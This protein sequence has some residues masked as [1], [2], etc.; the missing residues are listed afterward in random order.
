MTPL[1]PQHSFVTVIVPYFQRERGLLR[2]CVESV[3]AQRD[4]G[5]F[6]LI[7]VDDESPIPA[8]EELAGLCPEDP[9]VQII[10]QTNAGPGAARNTGLDHLPQGTEYVAFIDSDDWW[11]PGF[12]STAVAAL[13]QG[14]DIFF[15]NSKR[16]GFDENRFDWHAASNL[17]LIPTDH[18]LID[19][20]RALYA[21]KGAFFDYALVRSNIIS[22]SALAYR[23][24]SFPSLRFSTKL[25]NGQDRLFK[26]HLS[27]Q[28]EKV[29]FCP[30]ILVS[31]GTGINIYDS[32]KWGSAKSLRLLTNYIRLSKAILGELALNPVQRKTVLQQLQDT[33]FSLTASL[34]HLLKTGEA[35]DWGLLIRAVREDPPLVPQFIPNLCRIVRQRLRPSQAPSDTP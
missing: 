11:E 21:F 24:T 12:L 31:E 19:E 18:Q 15:A 33:R 20:A 34:V 17:R 6:H 29:V 13:E 2:K 10:Q 28:T 27:K 35:V 1:E 16:Y 25:F 7:V 26:L 30:R 4:A 5:P 22:T 32:A 9:R 23:Y 3:L 14:Y 8:A